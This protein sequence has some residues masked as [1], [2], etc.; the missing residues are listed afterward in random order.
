MDPRILELQYRVE[1]EH[2]DGSWG[3]M[4][5]EGPQDDAAAHDPERLWTLRRT[6]RCTACGE[7]VTLSP[8][9]DPA[10]PDAE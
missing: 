7:V 3:T 4:V 2:N 8:G 1:H 9:S 6:F 5:E 10:A